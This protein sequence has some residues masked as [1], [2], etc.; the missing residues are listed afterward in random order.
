[1]HKACEV[2]DIST[3]TFQ[4]WS[5][6]K[7]QDKRKGASKYNPRKMTMEEVKTIT[8]LCCSAEHKDQTPYG[9]FYDLLEKG[10]YL[11]SIR[12][13]YRILKSQGLLHHRSNRKSPNKNSVPPELIATGP[14]QVWTWDITWL[15]SEIRG[16]FFYSYM[17]ID[18]WDKTIVDWVVKDR[19]DEKISREL[20]ERALR[21][22]GNPNVHIHSDNGNPMKG[23]GLLSLFHHLKMN[24]SFSRPRVSN[25]NPFIESFFGTMKTSTEYPRRFKSN[26]QARQW[27][28]WFVDQ[29]NTA[30]RHSSNHYFTPKQMRS[31]EYKEKVALRNSVMQ[32]AKEANPQRWSGPE[33]QWKIE[34]V[35]YLNPSNETRKKSRKAA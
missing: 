4:R 3:R 26:D 13:F 8:D 1:M 24:Y 18:V 30:R 23:L 6:G 7:T 14:N 11:A 34:H 17:I 35:V 15:P 32:K 16:L 31:G 25:D 10:L 20:F 12:T 5:K 33:K 2:L 19:E 29:Y 28:A 22:Q 27:I 9:I 21:D